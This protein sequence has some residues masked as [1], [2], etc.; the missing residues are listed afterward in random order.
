MFGRNDPSV[1]NV[2]INDIN[3]ILG[4]K[5]I[6]QAFARAGRSGKYDC[7]VNTQFNEFLLKK[8]NNNNSSLNRVFNYDEWLES[9]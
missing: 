9:Y 3:K 4:F 5:T 2:V 7:V 1:K 8:F 6:M